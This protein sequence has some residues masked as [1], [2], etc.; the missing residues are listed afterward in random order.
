MSY[1]TRLEEFRDL[2][3][4]I[5]YLKYTLNSLIYWD[6]ITYMPP[7]GIEYRSQ[8][9]S[10]LADEQYKLMS[11]PAFRGHV[12]YFTG[13][14]KNDELTN[15]M[16]KRITRSSGF[17]SLIP[18]EEYRRY[19][20]LIARSEQVWEKAREEDDFESFRPYLENIM[21]TFRL[22]LIHISEPTRRS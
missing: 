4:R 13:H 7:D 5:E 16:M 12:K 2:I 19:I 17:I 21:E 6:K 22:S 20:E 11:G 14:R 15:A 10:F 9:M 3:R 1:E 18:E 8:V